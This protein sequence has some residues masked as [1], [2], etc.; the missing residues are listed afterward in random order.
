MA[1]SWVLPKKSDG[2]FQKLID[3]LFRFDGL[4]KDNSDGDD[5][6]KDGDDDDKDS[7]GDD[8]DSDGDDSND[9]MTCTSTS[10][11][12]VGTPLSL[13]STTPS[14]FAGDVL[15]LEPASD[16]LPDANPDTP[17]GIISPVV[18]TEA[19]QLKLEQERRRNVKEL[20]CLLLQA[21]KDSLFAD[22]FLEAAAALKIPE[23]QRI[24]IDN[25]GR[26]KSKAICTRIKAMVQSGMTIAVIMRKL[27]VDH[28]TLA[29]LL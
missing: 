6:D 12:T 20:H 4:D 29:H 16:L 3:E 26:P 8:K 18:L 23:D 2:E 15:P 17:H 19:Q 22:P 7:D 5:D 28:A 21:I 9:S 1:P 11:L 10:V 13:L 25:S 24:T 27:T 14:T